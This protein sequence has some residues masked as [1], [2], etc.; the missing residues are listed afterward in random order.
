M[1][2]RLTTPVIVLLLVLTL[3]TV[4]GAAPSSPRAT[5][6]TASG[7]LTNGDF[8][9]GVTGWSGY[10]ASLSATA[11]VAGKAVRV[12]ATQAS[13]Y[14]IS[15]LARPVSGTV[16][17]STFVAGGWVRSSATR[18]NVCLRVR[19]WAATA[20][21][22]S[23]Q[24][25][26][27]SSRNWQRLPNV[28]YTVRASG[29]SLDLDVFRD[30]ATIGDSF[31][32]DQL[33]LN[34]AFV[35]ATPLAPAGVPSAT[36]VTQTSLRV[37]WA[38]SPD[39]RTTGYR[40][41]RGGLVVSTTSGTSVVVGSL[42]CGEAS[43][44]SVVAFDALGAV[45]VPSAAT[46]GTATCPSSPTPLAPAGVPSAT[47][48]TQTSLRLTWSASPDSRTTSY[49][50][51]RAGLPVT[52]TPGTSVVVGSLSCG[53][54]SSYAVVAV[55][56]AGSVSA[57]SSAS[58][59]T[60]A[61]SPPPAAEFR[62][63]ADSSPWNSRISADAGVDAGSPAMVDQMLADTTFVGGFPIAVKEWTQPIYSANSATP[64]VDVTLTHLPY[65]GRVLSGVPM[66][67]GARPDPSSDGSLVVIDET[68][69]CEYDLARARPNA[70]GSWTAHFASTLPTGGS[71]FY[72]FSESPRAAGAGNA[73][74]VIRPE[75]LRAGRI[76]HA[77]A[78]TMKNT[79]A[80]GP[81]SPATGSDGWSTASGAVPEGAR[82]QLDPAL[83]LDSL[84]LNPWQKTIARALQEYGMILIDTGGGL[85]LQAENSQSTNEPYPWGDLSYS[86]LPTSLVER[87]R[88]LTLSPQF[89]TIYRYLNTPCATLR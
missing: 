79:K 74:G 73:A 43:I 68:T 85:S 70:D 86:Y 11:G 6:A 14:A 66:P 16:A 10:R 75:E 13:G 26:L 83:D 78:F 40:V 25:C 81:V 48:V 80:G 89:E 30:S 64:R 28:S 21:V 62:L 38:A 84:G 42:S 47:D 15:T 17:G 46:L 88:V 52:T 27:R 35:A 55:D 37:V 31:D 23:G 7:L 71:G 58:L 45:S 5:G 82:V 2:S 34:P 36:D 22:G 41:S 63:Y 87:F 18:R 67:A 4:A 1:S 65:A 56:A 49:R 29:N 53:T 39:G 72:P 44:F 33:S 24:A 60:A 76:D 57:P 51:S 3:T 20:V 12:A 9:A 8:E 19:E 54:V 77:L 59:G 50:V 32:V 61:C 69:G